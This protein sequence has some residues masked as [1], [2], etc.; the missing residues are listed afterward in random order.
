MKKIKPTLPTAAVLDALD[1]LPA[2][3]DFDG[4]I[5]PRVVAL[6]EAGVSVRAIGDTLRSSGVSVCDR[7]LRRRI[8]IAKGI[9]K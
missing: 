8:R 9:R 6:H 4:L 3:D 2:A 5:M 7:T 1:A